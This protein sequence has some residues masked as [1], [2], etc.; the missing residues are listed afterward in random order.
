MNPL[1]TR[2]SDIL[3]LL[4]NCKSRNRRSRIYLYSTKN[5]VSCLKNKEIVQ[6]KS[7]L[8]NE[9]QKVLCT[10]I[11]NN[12]N[13]EELTLRQS[14]RNNPNIDILTL[15]KSPK[16]TYLQILIVHYN[17]CDLSSTFFHGV[18]SGPERTEGPNY[19]VQSAP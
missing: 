16:N 2:K 19:A 18:K 7:T 13:K 11:R 5:D 17:T 8:E 1:S 6:D 12:S 9:E 3:E 15:R 14:I 10:S 4:N